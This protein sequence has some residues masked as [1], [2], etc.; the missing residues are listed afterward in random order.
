MA[1]QCISNRLSEFTI[2]VVVVVV[3]VGIRA[4][5]L[6][7]NQILQQNKQHLKE[8][9]AIKEQGW[10]KGQQHEPDQ[11]W[12]RELPSVQWAVNVFSLPATWTRSTLTQGTALATLRSKTNSQ[13]KNVT[14]LW[15]DI[16]TH[17]YVWD[18]PPPSRIIVIVRVNVGEMYVQDCINCLPVWTVTSTF[19]HLSTA[20]KHF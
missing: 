15:T 17:A 19:T 12:M 16:T 11:R 1:C 3:V 2:K 10:Q 20:L 8:P 14:V 5:V 4:A 13:L 7:V 18:I 6:A 9:Q